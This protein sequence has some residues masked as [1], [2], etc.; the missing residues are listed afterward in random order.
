MHRQPG[1]LAKRRNQLTR[2]AG[3]A[4]PRHILD[5]DDV[6]PGGLKFSSDIEVVLEVILETGAV[7]EI[8][9]ITDRPFAQRSALA[10]R[11]HRDSHVVNPVER[12]KNTK[13]VNAAR[14]RLGYEMPHHIIG[15]VG[16]ADR[17]TAAQQHL[18]QDVRYRRTQSRKP[19]PRV[20][21]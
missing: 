19:F 18:Q 20:F 8:C 12:I 15:V 2:R 6:G 21:V 17:I 4:H 9:R 10:N 5:A 14:R 16:V 1:L 11:V 7:E 13:Q 3:S